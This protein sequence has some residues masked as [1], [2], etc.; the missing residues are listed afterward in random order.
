MGQP[1]IGEIRMFG[2]NFA[3]VNWALCDGQLMPIAENEAL[4]QLIGTTYGGDGESTFALPDLRGR[5]PLHQ[6]NGFPL[7]QAA[8][9][10]TVTLTVQQIPAHSHAFQ[11]SNDVATATGPSGNLV[12]STNVA[13]KI[14]LGGTPPVSALAPSISP[15]GVSLPH[16]NFQPYQCITFIISLY[17]IFPSQT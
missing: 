9:A 11:A 1:F 2:S 15:A 10:E 8:G 7:G 16:S 12:A 6:G 4:F 14:Y 3:P 13:K 5:L 17:G